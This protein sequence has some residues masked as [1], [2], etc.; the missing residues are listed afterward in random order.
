MGESQ[1][2]W[3]LRAAAAFGL[4]AHGLRRP[5]GHSGSAWDAGPWVLR[6]G[7]RDPMDVELAAAAAAAAVLPV[8]KVTDPADIGSTTAVL[9]ERLPRQPAAAAALSDPVLAA[10]AGRAC[11]L[12]M[13][14]SPRCAHR[15]DCQLRRSPQPGMAPI[16]ASR[17]ESRIEE[18][19]T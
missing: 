12:F 18:E 7:S 6:A 10:A 5:G 9:L 8:P 15:S 14:G 16:E 17:S 2:E 4:D 11:G 3:V 19:L 1:C 13:P